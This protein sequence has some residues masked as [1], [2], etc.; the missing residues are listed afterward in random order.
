[1]CLSSVLL[2]LT[3]SAIFKTG[4]SSRVTL[5]DVGGVCKGGKSGEHGAVRGSGELRFPLVCLDIER[6]SAFTKEYFRKFY[7]FNLN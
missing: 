4:V 6:A 3:R 7:S 2:S 5:L 1:M